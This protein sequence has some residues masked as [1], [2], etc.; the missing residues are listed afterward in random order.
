MK[1]RVDILKPINA[2]NG[3]VPLTRLAAV[4]ANYAR[5][6]A[7]NRE[8]SDGWMAAR[9]ALC[10]LPCDANGSV[11]FTPT[12]YKII[13]PYKGTMPDADN[14]VARMK[15]ILDGCAMAFDIN[16][17]DLDLLGVERIHVSK[18]NPHPVYSAEYCY[19]VFTDN[20]DDE[21]TPDK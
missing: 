18:K 2:P 5:I 12:A 4:R 6:A 11:S 19:L 3:S 7:K 20:Y 15:H 10:T 1:L 21:Q 13:W 16:D 9:R 17:R 14:V 8:R